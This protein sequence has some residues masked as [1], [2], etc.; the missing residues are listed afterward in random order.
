MGAETVSN[1]RESAKAKA[2]RKGKRRVSIILSQLFLSTDRPTGVREIGMRAR[3]CQGTEEVP[4]RMKRIANEVTK[5]SRVQGLLSPTQEFR[6]PHS[7][8]EVR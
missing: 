8:E 2:T 3:P 1:E 4:G 5:D 6:W 7:S